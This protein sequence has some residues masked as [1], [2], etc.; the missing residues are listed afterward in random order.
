MRYLGSGSNSSSP[1]PNPE[2]VRQAEV[3]VTI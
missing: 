3:D 1:T 2:G